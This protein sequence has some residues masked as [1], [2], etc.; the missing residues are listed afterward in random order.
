[1]GL[2]GGDKKE[3][4]NFC[5]TIVFSGVAG[6]GI[7]S[8]G[9]IIAA[10]LLKEN[11][12]V[13]LYDE[14]P[15]LIR[16]G[17]NCVNI[18]YSPYAV[19]SQAQEIDI[20]VCLNRQ[21]FDQ[22]KSELKL[23]S[24]IIYDPVQVEITREDLE[25]Y[26]FESVEMPV[27]KILAEKK[28]PKIVGNVIFIAS[29]LSLAGVPKKKIR[30]LIKDEFKDKPNL[31]EGNLAA[32]DEGCRLSEE[33]FGIKEFQDKPTEDIKSKKYFMSGNEAV[34]LGAIKSGL[35]FYAAYPM[36]P[37]STLLDFL[38]SVQRD[39]NI[40]AKQTEDEIAAINMA[41]GASFAGARSM[42]GTSGGGFSLMVEGVGLA[43]ITETPIT[44]V[45]SQRP[46]P[47]TGMP[48]WTAQ[49]DLLFI[50]N[51][52]QDEFPRIILC[53][54]DIEECFYLSFEALNLADKYQLPVFILIDKFLSESMQSINLSKETGEIDRG[55]LLSERMLSRI[56][57]FNRYELTET[58]VSGRSIP[59]EKNGIFLANS[60]ESDPKGFTSEASATRIVNTSKRFSKIGSV[61]ESMPEI[62]IYGDNSAKIG[63]ITWGSTK[64]QTLESMRRLQTINKSV[65]MLSLNYIEPFPTDEI[66]RFIK[67]CKRVIIVE[68]NFTSQL[69][70]LIRMNLGV[71]IERKLLKFDGR[72]FFPHEITQFVLENL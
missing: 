37:A 34:C 28:L 35:Q 24:I 11:N 29:T 53:P 70:K 54:T 60:D 18:T 6:E 44:I 50:L 69:E 64:N 46:G 25:E 27:Q 43:A 71:S 2:L 59:G 3:I 65:K 23:N 66:E 52:S 30:K 14:Y 33:Y 49:G 72:P 40:V 12:N 21:A 56:G 31:I 68:N 4:K 13:F 32:L 5:Q 8:A 67:S 19:Y 15:S 38:S 20:L 62:N 7:K 61:K 39:F 63:I 9:K 22:H 1:M 26:S 17:Q 47:A 48:T 51:A 58:G 10:A 45:V 36:T 42:V 16:G 41:I 55:L 57:D